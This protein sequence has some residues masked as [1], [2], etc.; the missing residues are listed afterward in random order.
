MVLL[1]KGNVWLAI[2]VGQIESMCELLSEEYVLKNK[3]KSRSDAQKNDRLSALFSGILF[4]YSIG[5]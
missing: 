4:V 5:V 2:A 3:K 1:Q